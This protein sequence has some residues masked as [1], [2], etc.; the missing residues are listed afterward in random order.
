[1]TLA[2]VTDEQLD[3]HRHMTLGKVIVSITAVLV[4]VLILQSFAITY[5]LGAR[6]T[7]LNAAIATN[8]QQDIDIVSVQHSIIT[9]A[10]EIKLD[11]KEAIADLEESIDEK[12]EA[13]NKLIDVQLD[14]VKRQIQ[15]IDNNPRNSGP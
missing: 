2:P 15:L 11:Q 10:K 13:Q 3:R 1:M 4:P 9:T 12:F 7:E 5:F 6:N 8:T 14:E